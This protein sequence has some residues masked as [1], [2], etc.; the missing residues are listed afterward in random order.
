MLAEVD[1]DFGR[2]CCRS[3]GQCNFVFWSDGNV[4]KQNPVHSAA[5][6]TRGVANHC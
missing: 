5:E 3:G 6:S 2:A 4:V 1:D